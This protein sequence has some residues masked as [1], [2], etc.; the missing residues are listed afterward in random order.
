MEP[1]RE[2]RVASDVWPDADFEI[3]AASDGL[4][5]R[6]Y[7]A[8]F[9]SPSEDLGGFTETIAPRAVAQVAH[10]DVPQPRLGRG[11]GLDPRD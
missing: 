3:R 5:F 11:P 8:V 7:A 2:I 9:D 4:N 10:Q 6:G 1:T